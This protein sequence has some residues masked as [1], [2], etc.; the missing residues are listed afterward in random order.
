V[1]RHVGGPY[2]AWSYCYT[3]EKRVNPFVGNGKGII[4]VIE[5]PRGLL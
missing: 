5:Y 3:L 1:G 4:G 2:E